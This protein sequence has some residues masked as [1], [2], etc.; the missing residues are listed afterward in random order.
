[1][2]NKID[3][4]DPT[5]KLVHSLYI[6]RNINKDIDMDIDSKVLYCKLQL[7]NTNAFI[8]VL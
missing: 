8:Y 4:K 2:S 6:E 5:E 7:C 1:M 3:N